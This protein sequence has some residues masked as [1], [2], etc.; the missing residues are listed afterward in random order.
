LQVVPIC[1]FAAE[2]SQK[3]QRKTIS[4]DVRVHNSYEEFIA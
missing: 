4:C 3:T 1:I 2:K